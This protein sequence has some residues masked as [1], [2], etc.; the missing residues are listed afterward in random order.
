MSR[1]HGAKLVDNG[2]VFNLDAANIKSYPGS[3]TTWVDIKSSSRNATLVN[4]VAYSTSRNGAFTFDGV[5][6]YASVNQTVTS[7]AFTYE[8]VL[9]GTNIT[10]DQMYVGAPGAF[11]LRIT[12]SNAF[13]SITA[14]GSQR[15]LRHTTTLQ[16]NVPY[17][18]VS[19]YDGIR[20]KIYV[21]TV[22]TSGGT[23]NAAMTSWGADRI[24]RWRDTDQRSFV[25]DIYLI[26]GYNRELSAE[27]INQNFQALRGRYGI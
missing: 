4:G 17:H 9:K 5:D 24:G 23:L 6:D 15:T 2:L 18:I 27:E 14:G 11:Y 16:N 8:V 10:K 21:N 3:G 25:G 20:L 19:N 13:A 12:G 22:L 7:S 26:R 1:H